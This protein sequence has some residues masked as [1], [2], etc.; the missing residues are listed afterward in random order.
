MLALMMMIMT[1]SIMLMIDYQILNLNEVVETTC[2]C[3]R[4]FQTNA[5]VNRVL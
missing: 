2:L 4:E 5:P 3:A 1:L